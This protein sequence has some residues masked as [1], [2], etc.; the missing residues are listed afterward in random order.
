MKYINRTG[1][2]APIGKVVKLDRDGRGVVLPLS[3][4]T[5]VLGVVVA[6]ISGE[7]EVV[8]DGIRMT[9]INGV[10]KSGDIVY[11]R[12]TVQSGA[13]GSCYASS[14]PTTPYLRI[15][16]SVE[17]G[18]SRMTRVQMNIGFV[19]GGATTVIGSVSGSWIYYATTWT[20]PPSFI[21]TITGGHVYSY[22]LDG[23]I[24][25]RLVPIPYNAEDDAF[26]SRFSSPTLSG[27]IVT[28]G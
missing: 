1:I 24:R 20:S 28:R 23:V 11:L 12:K 13:P 7:V 8:S 19:S 4:D 10:F 2:T 17:A 25:Y 5:L 22:I 3:S 26:Y 15:G 21:G 14:S 16:T 6:V 9:F 18:S 27:L